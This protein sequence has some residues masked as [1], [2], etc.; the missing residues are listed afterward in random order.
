LDAEMVGKRT[1]PL[2]FRSTELS[3]VGFKHYF[4]LSALG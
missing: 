2:V 3:E 1:Q 4:E